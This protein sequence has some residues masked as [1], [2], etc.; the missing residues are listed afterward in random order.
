MTSKGNEV[1]SK[2]CPCRNL[3]MGGSDLWSYTL[4]LDHRGTPSIL[5]NIYIYYHSLTNILMLHHF[6]VPYGVP[7]FMSLSKSCLIF[8]PV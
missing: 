4:P 3:N 7:L 2:I 5:W 6:E 1:K 8:I